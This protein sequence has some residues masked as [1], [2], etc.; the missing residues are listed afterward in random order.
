MKLNLVGPVTKRTGYGIH[1]TN[2]A[3]ALN[4]RVEVTVTAR[5]QV[6]PE[7]HS[8][9]AIAE[10]LRPEF[11]YNAP[12][13]CVWHADTMQ[14][15]TGAKRIGFPVFETDRLTQRE[16]YQ[17]KNLD[18][19]LVASHWAKGVIEK[20]FAERPDSYPS[21]HVVGEGYDPTLFQPRAVTENYMTLGWK[22]PYI[23]NVG[24]WELRK[25]HPMLIKVLGQ[26]ANEGMKFTFVGFWGSIFQQDWRQ[27]ADHLV[28]EA[29][30][31]QTAPGRYEK[32]DV[33]LILAERLEHHTDIA[34]IM[35]M[36]DF[37]VYPHSAEGWCLPILETMGCGRPVIATNYSGPSEYLTPDVGMLIDPMGFKPIFDPV[38]FKN[39]SEGKW[40]TVNPEQLKHSIK[41]MIE[42]PDENRKAIGVK[43]LKRATEFTWDESAKRVIKALE[44]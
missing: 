12:T 17:L 39:R 38:F 15:F 2:L 19:V 9:P 44:K 42:M 40:A 16:I 5:S 18:K 41:L 6:D 21:V 20:G 8:D 32:N 10:L 34:N 30:F 31:I 26:L 3:L 13:I 7:L 35:A 37:G 24:K 11:D 29:G 4:N 43:A 36:C 14:L 25:G 33:M 28:T 22:R 23:Q 27:Q 1:F